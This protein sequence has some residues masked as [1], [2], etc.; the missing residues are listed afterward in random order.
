MSGWST[1]GE[2]ACPICGF[3]TDSKWLTNGRKWCY[4]CHRRWLPVDHR[5]RLDTRSFLGR[6]ELR[7]A[8]VPSSGKEILQKLENT[9]FLVDNVNGG[10][11]KKKS[12][13][14]MLQYWEHLLLRHNLDPM[15]IEKNVQDNIVGTVL[16]QEK[17][18]KDNYKTRL[19]LQEL[20]MRKE[21]HPKKRPRSNVTF[22]P[23]ACYQMSR[24]EKTEF[25]KCL[26]S[27]KPPDEFSCNISRCVHLNERKLIGMKSYDC[28]V[29]MQEY[30]PIALRGTLPDHVSSVIIEL[31]DFFRII[32]YKDLS[33][34][35]LNFI[36]AKVSL[37]LCKL[38]KI[39]PPSFFTVMVHLV[40]HLTREVRLG[41]PVAF[42]WMYPIERYVTFL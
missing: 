18:S 13:F 21:L 15:H 10:P 38:E 27:I 34:D 6:H 9:E 19:D 30:L 37:T 1:K 24:A 7:V 22:I 16:G 20:G 23:K 25:L 4:M 40:I 33:D 17:K 36:E 28:H 3:D 11:W 39:F 8:P 35:D 5:W 14:F 41:G 12:I 2:L 26:K 31:C 32:C 42:R 29:L